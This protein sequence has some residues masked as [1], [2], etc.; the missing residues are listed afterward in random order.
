MILNPRQRNWETGKSPN[1]KI[2][3]STSRK[4]HEHQN[5]KDTLQ[6]HL[7][8]LSHTHGNFDRLYSTDLGTGQERPTLIC[9]GARKIWTGDA[10]TGWERMAC[11]LLFPQN[12]LTRQAVSRLDRNAIGQPPS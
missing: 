6:I 2:N 5:C 3:F 12:K 9:S 1:Q 7:V 4:L 11:L 8:R 10:S